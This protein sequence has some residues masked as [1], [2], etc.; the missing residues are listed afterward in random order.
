ME[1][2]EL[3]TQI[4]RIMDI[5]DKNIHGGYA[6]A[7][8]FLRL[9]AGSDSEFYKALDFKVFPV[10]TSAIP[11][12]VI[13]VLSS[14]ITYVQN[15]LL[16]SLSLQREIQIETVSDYLSQA[17]DLLNN[18][19]IHPAAP[20]IIIG[21]SL[22]E[23]LRTWLEDLD[24]DIDNFPAGLDH[25]A[26]QLRKAEKITKQDLKDITSWAGIRNDAAHGN[27]ENVNDK[28]RIRIMLESVNLFIRKYSR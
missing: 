8:E 2:E 21:A 12:R 6:Q 4:R 13:T 10:H 5:A 24:L 28:Q 1:K 25:Y 3:I 19:K 18:S 11:S 27:W 17:E 23:Y 22:E 7:K 20:A 16:R 15:D 14:F 26:K 9:Y